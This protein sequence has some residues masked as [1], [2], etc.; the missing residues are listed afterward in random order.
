MFFQMKV[1]EIG[2]YDGFGRY[3][4]ARVDWDFQQMKRRCVACEREVRSLPPKPMHVGIEDG[5]EWPD[6]LCTYEHLPAG[7]FVFSERVVKGLQEAALTGFE[8]YPVIID[9][10]E[11]EALQRLAP[12]E[13]FYFHILG[14]MDIDLEA[15]GLGFLAPCPLCGWYDWDS[16]AARPQP[17]KY[18][19]LPE[20]WDGGD[21]FLLRNLRT[22]YT[23][24]SEKVLLLAREHRWT[25]FRFYTM[26]TVLERTRWWPGVDYLGP[27]WPPQWYADP[28]HWGKSVEEWVQDLCNPEGD[29]RY[30][31]SFALEELKSE[32]M[33]LLV[34]ALDSPEELTRL[35]MAHHLLYWRG[36]GTAVS[37]EIA[38]KCAAIYMARLDH[39]QPAFRRDAARSLAY[40][41]SKGTISLSREELRR[42]RDV[43]AGF[44]Q[45]HSLSLL[46]PE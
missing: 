17:T 27:T 44:K 12:P 42:L 3:P 43:L 23:F 25:N 8:P 24:C 46:P 28:P 9:S 31:A 14:R 15:S 21:F 4:Y 34:A 35:H 18:V 29:I 20:T 1:Q 6:M 13:Y 2:Q 33:P 26:G 19:P 37:E 41:F 16:K 7:V 11:T 10:I 39:E 38:Q 40:W 30:R 45:K 5:Y 32:A 36:Q 22:G